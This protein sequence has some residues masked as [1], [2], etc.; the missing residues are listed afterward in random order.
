[1][2]CADIKSCKDDLQVVMSE[3]WDVAFLL[4]EIA[5]LPYNDCA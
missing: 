4:A 1:M 5:P 2:R 3:E